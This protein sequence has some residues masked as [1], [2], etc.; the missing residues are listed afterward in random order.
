MRSITYRDFKK[1]RYFL[2]KKRNRKRTLFFFHR[3]N[4][5]T[6][7]LVKEEIFIHAG[8]KWWN[9]HVTKHMVGRKIGEFA[10]TRKWRKKKEKKKKKK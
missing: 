4:V 3:G 6:P 2:K 10:W 1:L 8:K 9:L 7:H 5:I